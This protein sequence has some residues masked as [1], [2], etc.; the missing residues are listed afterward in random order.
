M[1][2]QKEAVLEGV[3]F[4]PDSKGKRS[5][6]GTSKRVWATAMGDDTG[7]FE[8]AIMGEKDWRHKYAPFVVQVADESVRSKEKCVSIAKRGLEQVH[9]EFEFIRDGVTYPIKEA[10][11]ALT[12]TLGTVAVEGKSETKTTELTVPFEGKPLVGE[13]LMKKVQDWITYGTG[14]PSVGESVRAVHKHPEWVSDV[15][16]NKVFVVIG[17]TSALGPLRSLL[18][19][20]ATVVAIS[21]PSRKWHELLAFA[22]ASAGT[23]IVPVPEGSK[24]DMSDEELAGVAGADLLTQTPEIRSM[25]K[26]VAPGKQLVIGCYV[27][28]DG[29]AHVRASVAMDLICEEVMQA[30]KD[31]ALAYLVS[32]ATA[33][34]IPKEAY[35]ASLQHLKASP[36]W[37]GPMAFLT[38]SFTGFK[39]NAREPIKATDSDNTYYVHDGVSVL[40][41]PNYALAKSMQNWRA[42][43]ARDAGH[44]VSANCAPPARTESML[45]N[46]QVATALKG[47][48]AFKPTMSFDYQT[49]SPIMTLLLISDISDPHSPAR[50]SNPKFANPMEVFWHNSWH[51][52]LWRAAHQPQATGTASYVLGLMH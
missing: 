22:R 8:R 46:K 28:L 39:K 51:G 1:S 31:T 33:H 27:Y 45:K 29:G 50:G 14:E 44:T 18:T 12:T 2:E 40:Q 3:Q 21:R 52:G 36:W 15:V 41:G 16:A 9:K 11:T 23:L 20:G 30:R 17:A 4:P 49:V 47:M 38:G 19:L 42:A 6:T 32:M 13:A 48:T 43:L 25:L 35:D 24:E 26:A 5:T 7:A 37:S 10:M 34:P